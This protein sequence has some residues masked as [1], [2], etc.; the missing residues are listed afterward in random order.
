MRCLTPSRAVL[1]FAAA[2]FLA[3]PVLLA[4]TATTTASATATAVVSAT[5]LGPAGEETANGAVTVSRVAE[6]SASGSLDLPRGGRGFS[7]ID[8]FRVGGGTNASFA[9]T[10]PATAVVRNE[11]AQL[12]VSGFRAAGNRVLGP[13]G[14]SIVSV[15]ADVRVPPGQAPGRYAGSY[16]VTIAYD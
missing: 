3:A 9:I 2:G 16:T 1:Y 12:E 5:V 4:K 13:D 8:R 11:S 14:T 10:L 7:T 15:G 6:T